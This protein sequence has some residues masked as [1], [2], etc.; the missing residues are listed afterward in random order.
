MKSSTLLLALCCT[1]VPAFL[2]AQV[3]DSTA[4]WPNGTELDFG[5]F[6]ARG[7]ERFDSLVLQNITDEPFIIENIRSSCGC[8]AVD[9]PR[10]PLE[11]GA[12]I[13]IPVAFRCIKSGY[14]EKHLDVYLSHL[15]KRERI[16]VIAD[17]PAR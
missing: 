1:L 5:F 13:R 4:L 9:W 11:P 10:E 8:T 15:E 14:V 6:E 12:I 16:Y 2:P 3:T 17:C 7:V